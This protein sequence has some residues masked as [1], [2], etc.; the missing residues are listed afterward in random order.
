MQAVQFQNT[1]TT[2]KIEKNGSYVPAYIFVLQLHT[3]EFVIGH[4]NNVCRRI[5]SINSGCNSSVKA[6]SV[7][8]VVG[9]RE[10]NEERTLAGVVSKFCDTYGASRV[11][12]I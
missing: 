12:A 11:I 4:A 3:G 9:I 7:N 6:L 2:S 8:R 1:T 10:Q 5:A